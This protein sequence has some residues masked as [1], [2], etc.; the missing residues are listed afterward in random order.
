MPPPA[1]LS[2]PL[3]TGCSAMI[4][5]P[6]QVNIPHRNG[7]AP[8][9]GENLKRSIQDFQILFPFFIRAILELVPSID[10]L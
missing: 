2:P 10:Q 5:V 7:D 1:P 8:V 4:R 3:G 6:K 9:A